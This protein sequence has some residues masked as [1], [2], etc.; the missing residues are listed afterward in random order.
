MAVTELPEDV[1]SEAVQVA[2]PDPGV[3]VIP[4]DGEPVVVPL[5]G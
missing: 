4:E 2:T 5:A 1:D 3:E